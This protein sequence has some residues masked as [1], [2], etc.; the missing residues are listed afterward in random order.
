MLLSAMMVLL[1]EPQISDLDL[2]LLVLIK[3]VESNQAAKQSTI[4]I[5]G[6][7][8]PTFQQ[9]KAKIRVS[10]QVALVHA[11]GAIRSVD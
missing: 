7:G 8:I 1:V 10:V 2:D 3:M 5:Y 9:R 11:V 4:I 6:K